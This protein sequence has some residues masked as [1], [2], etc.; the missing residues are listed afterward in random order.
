MKHKIAPNLRSALWIILAVLLAK[1]SKSQAQAAPSKFPS[2]F[3][4]AADFRK[5]GIA[6]FRLAPSGALVPLTP[7]RAP[8]GFATGQLII[9]KAGRFAYAINPKRATVSHLS[10]GKDG[11]LTQRRVA[12]VQ[13]GKEY[14]VLVLDEDGGMAYASGAG[15]D[16]KVFRY[17]LGKDGVLKPLPVLRV[18]DAAR[19]IAYFAKVQTA[20]LLLVGYTLRADMQR[21]R[22][23]LFAAEKL[24]C[25]QRDKAVRALDDELPVHYDLY[26]TRGT[27][28][29]TKIQSL[30][31][32]GGGSLSFEPAGKFAYLSRAG[33]IDTY[34][35][36]AQGSLSLASTLPIAT[37]GRAI[38]LNLDKSG[39]F[40]YI[41]HHDDQGHHFLSQ[42]R[43]WDDGALVALS[44]QQVATEGEVVNETLDPTSKFLY[45]TSVHSGNT[46]NRFL[47]AYR[48]GEDGQLVRV[49]AGRTETGNNAN[50]PIFDPTGRFAYIGIMRPQDGQKGAADYDVLQFQVKPDGTLSPLSP[51]KIQ[52]YYFWYMQ[53][54][55][56]PAR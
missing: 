10:I 42:F 14:S 49:S 44:P 28:A 35:V 34:R 52:M 20:R 16:G 50:L 11:T 5:E 4:Y 3:A 6:Q 23:R 33:A 32:P 22:E 18:P 17:S 53:F 7:A 8:L 48:I 29:P 51:A 56:R 40:L 2:T 41:D 55:Q 54:V 36:S 9:D 12:D 27:K 37:G 47:V 25:A 26:S 38:G 19:V 24:G 13:I 1:S 30:V 15:G 43:R 21:Y 31:V 39:R 46:L 45:V